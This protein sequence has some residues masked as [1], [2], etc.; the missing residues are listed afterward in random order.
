MAADAD[1][2][3]ARHLSGTYMCAGIKLYLLSSFVRMSP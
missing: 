1:H 2:G 3:D